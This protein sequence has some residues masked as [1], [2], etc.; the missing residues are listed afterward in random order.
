MESYGNV[1]TRS[2]WDTEDQDERYEHQD[3]QYALQGEQYEH[4]EQYEEQNEQYQQ[5]DE[6]YGVNE[7]GSDY[8]NQLEQFEPHQRDTQGEWLYGKHEES[9]Q[10]VRE[11]RFDRSGEESHDQLYQ[12]PPPHPGQQ[13]PVSHSA[14][15]LFGR[16]AMEHNPNRGLPSGN[17]LMKDGP[18][19]SSLRKDPT[20]IPG[21][22]GFEKEEAA[23]SVQ[24]KSAMKD[25]TKQASSENQDGSPANQMIESLGKIVSQLQTLQG[26][27]SSL[28]LLQTLPKGQQEAAKAEAE[29]M[30]ATFIST[31]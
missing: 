30:S 15:E 23:K 14:E 10:K 1:A 6:L 18:T 11:S 26:L 9:R 17:Q 12:K 20:L 28:Q 4:E 2:R 21:L 19:I 5:Q 29:R 27:T 25:E 13:D 16:H 31:A 7:G 3:D 8:H 24:S 22:G